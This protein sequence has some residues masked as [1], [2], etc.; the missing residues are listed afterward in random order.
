MEIEYQPP[1][2]L[3][4]LV[5]RLQSAGQNLSP[6]AEEIGE[7]WLGETL[8]RFRS[9]TDPQGKRWKPSRRATAQG[10]QTLVDT[11]RLRDSV[12][13]EARAEEVAIGSNVVYAAIHQLGGTIKPKTQKALAFRGADGGLV[14]AR[15]VTLPARPYLGLGPA[16]A[17]AMEDVIDR[18]LEQLLA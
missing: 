4:K 13:V 8:Q 6:L 7:A 2:A 3:P 17:A 15:S 9:G 11:G 18:W 10:G 5:Q 12:T 16:D 14:M 1:A